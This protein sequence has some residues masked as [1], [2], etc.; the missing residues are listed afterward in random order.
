[1]SRRSLVQVSLLSPLASLFLN[2]G[3]AAAL[4]TLRLKP[5][6]NIVIIAPHPDDEVLG[7]GGLIQQALALGDQ[8]WVVC[9]TSGDGSWPAAWRVTGNL[10]PGPADYRELGRARIEEAKAGARVLGLDTTHLIFLGFPDAELDRLVFEHYYDEAPVKSS[11]TK[12]DRSLYDPL[13]FW[14]RGRDIMLALYDFVG[15][16]HV[17]RIFLPH[18]LDA[19]PDHWAVA[20]LMPAIREFWRRCNDSKFPVIRYYLVHRPAY[21]NSYA[22]EA[23]CLNPPKQL[24]GAGHHW[25]TLPVAAQ[26]AA[27]KRDA[28]KCHWSQSDLFTPDPMSYA[29]GN[30][31]FDAPDPDGGVARGDAPAAGFLFG[32]RIDSITASLSSPGRSVFKLY[33]AGAPASELDYRLYVWS[34]GPVIISHTADLQSDNSQGARANIPLPAADARVEIAEPVCAAFDSGLVAYLPS[35]WFNNNSMVYFTADV[36]WKGNLLNHAGVGWV[37]PSWY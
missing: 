26:E 31:L 18:P 34:S 13:R 25:Y 29:A 5:H 37:V 36:R 19:H 12:M 28:L 8:V 7:C 21:P 32:P 4:D 24:T 14:Y 23:G 1:V 3:L 35:K 10:F 27:K 9:V 30:E 20:A 16:R 17:D 22:D 6:E 2:F 15:W 33:L 11:H